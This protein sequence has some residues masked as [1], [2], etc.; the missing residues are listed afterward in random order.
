ML[1]HLVRVV[2]LTLYKF[3]FI[4]NFGWF[5]AVNITLQTAGLFVYVTGLFG[6]VQFFCVRCKAETQNPSRLSGRFYPDG[7][8]QCADG[9]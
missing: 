9:G 5:G 2:G 8:S 6:L 4:F 7:F 3:L 1:F